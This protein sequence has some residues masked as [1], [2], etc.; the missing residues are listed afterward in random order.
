MNFLREEGLIQPQMPSASSTFVGKR[1]KPFWAVEF[2]LVMIVDGRNLRYEARWPQA[3]AA[4]MEEPQ[5]RA[6]GQISIAA[7][8][9]PGTV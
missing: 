5:A 3:D 8:F 6:R 9:H 1:A 7:A 4:S 2:D